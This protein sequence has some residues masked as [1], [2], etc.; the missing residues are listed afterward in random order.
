MRI[1]LK[2]HRHKNDILTSK[3]TM[4]IWEEGTLMRMLNIGID[5]ETYAYLE[6][7]SK[8]TGK[9]ISELAAEVLSSSLSMLDFNRARERMDREMGEWKQERGFGLNG[10]HKSKTISHS[11]CR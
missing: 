11:L 3:I 5:D 8:K 1:K 9:G 4:L 7:Y 10:R 2:V 6:G